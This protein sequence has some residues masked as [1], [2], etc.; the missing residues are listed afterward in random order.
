MVVTA[1]HAARDLEGHRLENPPAVPHLEVR[2]LILTP[3]AQGAEERIRGLLKLIARGLRMPERFMD[4]R[5]A[6]VM[7]RGPPEQLLGPA[8]VAR[9]AC[10]C[11]LPE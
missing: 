1:P 8:E 2:T 10:F 6:G 11:R 4:L 3:Q 5:V 9:G 7:A